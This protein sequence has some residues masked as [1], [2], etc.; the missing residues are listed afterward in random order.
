[1]FEIYDR[2]PDTQAAELEY[3]RA[4]L[5]GSPTTRVAPRGRWWRRRGAP[6]GLTASLSMQ[7][8]ANERDTVGARD[9]D[10]LVPRSV[11]PLVGRVS[12]L[13]VLLGVLDGAVQAAAAGVAIV[14]GDAGVGKTRLLGELIDAATARGSLVLVGHCV[15]LG[16]AP[17]PYL[18]FSEAFARLAIE[19]PDLVDELL[20]AY[21]PIT[22][23]IPG[24]G[25]RSPDDR[26]DRGELFEA[27]LGA[28]ALLA[29]EGTRPVPGRGR[30]LGRPGHPRPARVPV[31]P[32]RQRAAGHRRQLPQRRPAP[33][34]PAAPDP[35]RS[36]R[37][38]PP[39]SRIQLDPLPAAD[40]RSLIQAI[41]P[42]SD[43]RRR[44]VQHRRRGP[45]GTRSSP[46]SCVAASEQCDDTQHLPWQLADLLLVRLDRL[47]DDAR[48]TRAGGCGRRAPGAAQHARRRRR[49]AR[50][51]PRRGAARR[52]RRA[53]A[54][55]DHER[56]RLH[57]P[58]RAAGRGRLR[59]PAAGRAGAAARSL[60]GSASPNIPNSAAPNSPGTRSPRTTSTPPMRRA[61]KPVKR[62]CR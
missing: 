53:R 49:P 17:P 29:G 20:A 7:L 11:A 15:D 59:R 50:R 40:V 23:L 25:S 48:E 44:P 60:R 57:L 61:S 4:R 56:S 52:D 27:V 33:P 12:E 32:G 24:R 19:R 2:I 36:G 55:T 51:P 21:P 42:R 6:L 22:R 5:I 38:C 10:V 28:L 37:G 9:D 26:L 35:G 16:D 39:V 46:R 3:R 8:L 43:R 31:H 13:A 30:A 47:G 41:H 45:T 18:P 54:A 34:S 14:G 58:A 1:M 62:R